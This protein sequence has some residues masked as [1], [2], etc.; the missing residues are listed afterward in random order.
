MGRPGPPHIHPHTKGG[1]RPQPP[2]PPRFLPQLDV[3]KKL[4][5]K[6][7]YI[8]GFVAIAQTRGLYLVSAPLPP[9]LPLTFPAAPTPSLSERLPLAL[10]P[11]LS[12]NI[13]PYS[14]E[15]VVLFCLIRFG[16]YSKGAPHSGA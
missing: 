6:Q 15:C 14:K 4:W 10:P 1:R 12:W 16:V 5:Q 13:I 11:T 8:T 3:G 9:A 7:R 2:P